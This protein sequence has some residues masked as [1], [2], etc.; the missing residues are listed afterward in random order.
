ME[1]LS[2][3]RGQAHSEGSIEGPEGDASVCCP[4]RQRIPDPLA[5]VLVEAEPA[6]KEVTN[7]DGYMNTLEVLLLFVEEH[8]GAGTVDGVFFD[9]CVDKICEH[10][11]AFYG[12]GI[13]KGLADGHDPCLSYRDVLMAIRREEAADRARREEA[14]R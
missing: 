12:W 4:T 1:R 13:L 6:W 2:L 8:N 10:P 5:E 7:K 14:A 11:G 9:A 3:Y